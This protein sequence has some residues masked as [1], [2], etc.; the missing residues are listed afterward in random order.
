MSNQNKVISLG[1][2]LLA[3]VA[4]WYLWNKKNKKS[5]SQY[6]PASSIV[7]PFM[8]SLTYKVDKVYDASAPFGG[9]GN[10]DFMSVPGTFQ[11]MVPPRFGMLRSFQVTELL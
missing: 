3:A 6:V 2:L 4:A 11:S 7:E 10:G 5:G 1:L 8:P 9:Q